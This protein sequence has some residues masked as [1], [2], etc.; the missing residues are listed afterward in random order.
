MP[1]PTISVSLPCSIAS[2]F[3]D[4]QGYPSD[5]VVDKLSDRLS[6]E[7]RRPLDT[8][9]GCTACRGV[10]RS[11]RAAKVILGYPGQSNS[12]GDSFPVG[13]GLVLRR[14]APISFIRPSVLV[15]TVIILL[16]VDMF[17]LEA[18]TCRQSYGM[19]EIDS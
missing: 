7:E 12:S 2:L 8:S 13:L 6:P 3:H 5:T 9:S 11:R 1:S 17:D 4:R 10:E 16:G 18:L 19:T 15:F 14:F